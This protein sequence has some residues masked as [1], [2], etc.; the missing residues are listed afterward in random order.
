MTD[1]VVRPMLARLERELP[2]GPEWL[3]EPKWDGFRCLVFRDGDDV[4]LRSRHGNRLDRYFPELV[5]AVRAWAGIRLAAD[6][7][8]VA[9][10]GFAALM[11][12]I[13][14]AAS[15]VEL[16][17]R[18]VPVRLVLFDLLALGGDDLVERPFA[19]R[20]AV[21]ESLA[22]ADPVEVTPLTADA[23]EAE[24]WLA[25]HEGVIAKHRE[26]RYEA[27]RRAMVKVKRER[28]A[29]CVVA[30][31]RPVRGEEAVASL[32]LGLWSG[33]ELVHVGVAS[34][35]TRRVRQSVFEE[36]LPLA[37]LLDDHPWRAGYSLGG[38]AT[39]RLRGSAGRWTPEMPLDWIPLA[40]KRVAEVAYD[41]V[42]AGRFR[43][44][45]RLVRWRPDR[46]A[47]SCTHDQL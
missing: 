33:D 35:F 24:R 18:E 1:A 25:E 13:H 26:L 46:D 3:Y 31:M 32:L 4:E 30:G 23:G 29:D 10:A 6:G 27:G 43:H 8:V 22:L 2:R 11:S 28:T 17:R 15:R 38:G 7:E 14:P 20:R 37:V 16:L 9:D 34:S 42:D 39:G 47:G 36:L 5:E 44:P 40:P 45:A 19:E 21:L 41:Q 12:R